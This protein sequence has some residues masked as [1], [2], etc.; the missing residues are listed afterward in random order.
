MGGRPWEIPVRS[1]TLPAAMVVAIPNRSKGGPAMTKTTNAKDDATSDR[2]MRREAV[3]NETGLPT[4]TLYAKIAKGEFPRPVKIGTRAVAWKESEV[5]DWQ[6][7]RL[8]ERD[9]AAA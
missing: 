3:C 5:K 1:P 9:R 4:S 7:Q 2:F 8:A 6:A